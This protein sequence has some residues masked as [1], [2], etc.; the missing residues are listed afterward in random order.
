[1]IFLIKLLISLIFL[2]LSLIRLSLSMELTTVTT[3]DSPAI[4]GFDLI[5]YHQ[6]N[7]NKLKLLHSSINNK[8]KTFLLLITFSSCF[9]KKPIN[10]NIFP[11]TLLFSKERELERLNF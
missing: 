11:F 3:Y 10:S 2:S 8:S 9:T 6:L 1:M 5:R 7:T 4:I